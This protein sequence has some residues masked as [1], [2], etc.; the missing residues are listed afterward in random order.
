MAQGIKSNI[1]RNC[2]KCGQQFK[3]IEAELRR[4][5]GKYCSVFCYRE[6]P[7]FTRAKSN[8]GK[9]LVKMYEEGLIY[10][11]FASGER[12]WNWK[13]G[14]SG[15]K[16]RMR[17]WLAWKAWRR[18]VFERDGY[19]CKE[20]GKGGFLEPHHIVPLSKTLS[21]AFD[22]NNGITLCRPCHLKTIRKEKLFEERYLQ[23][24]NA[25]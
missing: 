3:T 25:C 19:L 22:V 12:H 9:A 2:L 6:S 18:L 10:K 21:R 20:C 8:G 13:G 4:G 24:V 16:K 15:I 1:T 14:I 11:K 17:N 7:A 23:M 5:G